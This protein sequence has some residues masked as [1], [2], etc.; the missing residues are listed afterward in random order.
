MAG[1]FDPAVRAASPLVAPVSRAIPLATALFG[2]VRAGLRN[3]RGLVALGETG[4]PTRLAQI[5]APPPI[6]FVKGETSLAE[7][8]MIAIVGSRN[9]SAV[10]QKFARRLARDFGAA[11][12]VVASGLA[13]GIDGAAHRAAIETGTV[14]LVAGGIDVVYPPENADLQHAIGE[15]GLLVSERPPGLRP[16]ARD[17]PRRN[18]LISG[19]SVAVV[20][21]E[22]AERSGSLITARMAGEQGRDVFAVPGNPLDPRAAGTNRLLREGAGLGP[23][24]TTSSRRW[25]QCS[26][27]R[28]RF[29]TSGR[30]PPRR[31][32]A[33]RQAP[34][35]PRATATGSSPRSAS[36]PWT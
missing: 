26:A 2:M 11:G 31:E 34:R 9:G 7:R 1:G 21:V 16:T 20:V 28:P 15:Q 30:A 25:R 12:F 14:A 8:P 23:R 22:A 24:P 13:R 29:V 18:R 33:R 19:V 5:D 17:F 36:R 4:Y 10:G 3:A 6:L 27:E 32:R 35:S